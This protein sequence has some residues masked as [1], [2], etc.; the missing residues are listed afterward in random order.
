MQDAMAVFTRQPIQYR[1]LTGNHG[2][3]INKAPVPLVEFERFFTADHI[4]G[5]TVPCDQPELGEVPNNEGIGR[6]THEVIM[7][8]VQGIFKRAGLPKFS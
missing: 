6:G 1:A 5:G 2:S 3:F 7:P 8:Q 4:M